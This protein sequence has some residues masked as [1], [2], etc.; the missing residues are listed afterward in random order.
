MS[1]H[2]DR[3][4]PDSYGITTYLENLRRGQYQIPTFQREVV[5]E[6]HRVKRLWDSI[7]KFYPLGSILVWRTEIRLQNHREIG[8]HPLHNEPSGGGFQYLL[9]GQQRTTALLTSMDGGRIK[10]QESWD[11]Q[12]YVDLTIDDVD[13]VEDDSWRERFLFWDEIDDRDGQLIRNRA[14]RQRYDA[15][16]IVKLKDISHQYPNL[17][18]RLVDSGH[19]DYDDPA[20]KQ[21]RNFKQVFDNYKLSF[22]E[23]RGIEVAEVCQIFERI[24]QAGQPLSMFDIVV[25]KTF[26]PEDEK[27]PGFYLRGLFEHFRDK[28]TADGSRFAAV[29][30]MTLLQVL[31][32]I[33][34]DSVAESGVHNIT[35]R[36]L[37]VIQT[38]HLE[39][40]WKDGMKAISKVFDF[41]ENHLHLHGPAL[42]PY[43]YFYMTLASYFFR[44]AHPDY[45]LLM[46]YFWYYSFHNEDLLSNTT[47]LRDHLRRL[48][49]VRD[50]RNF[51]FDRFLIDRENLRRTAY[52]T[53]GRLSRAM[54]SLYAHQGPCDWAHPDRSVLTQ[55]YYTLADH[56]NLHHIFPLDFCEKHLGDQ[57]RY[58][59]SL[60]NIAYLTK[61]T[62]LQISNRN[63]LEYLRNYLGPRFDELQRTHLL[64]ESIVEWTRSEQMPH[65]ALD[66]FVDARLGLVIER[67]QT[68]LADIPFE[69]IDTRSQGIDPGEKSAAEQ[70]TPQAGSEFSG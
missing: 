66:T 44:N 36:Y 22:I 50:G 47:H 48:H 27:V 35:D 20:R 13:E 41:L 57:V 16:I 9:D 7:Y 24:N 11:P 42:V 6:G 29:D 37:N 31:A 69:V 4:K 55:V 61:I 64:P 68:Y 43:R 34:R 63:P 39:A 59:D 38:D 54:L 62:N 32:V 17:E 3:I 23:L 19:D 5:W 52:S 60:L 28:L 40:V 18:R 10:G 65:G 26:R 8:G 33:V 1:S 51:G 53:R 45:P 56:P 25:A 2:V 12:L 58:A 46:R 21:L 67:L 30:N 70:I 49:E 15:G 14:R